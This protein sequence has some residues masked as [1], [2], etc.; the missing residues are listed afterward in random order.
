MTDAVGKSRPPLETCLVSWHIGRSN[1]LAGALIAAVLLLV[2]MQTSRSY[3]GANPHCTVMM[4][5][6]NFGSVTLSASPIDTTGTLSIICPVEG[7]PDQFA[8]VSIEAGS[9]GDATSRKM[10]NGTDAIRYDLYK[11]A[12]HT[13]LWGSWESGYAGSGLQA[14]VPRTTTNFTVYGR[15]FASQSV[16]SGTYTS[17]FSVSPRLTSKDNT[18][19]PSCPPTQNVST[20][21]FTATVT[22]QGSCSVSAATLNFGNAGSLAT[23]ID[24]TTSINVTC[25]TGTPYQIGLNAGNG[26]GAT[27]SNRKMTY[28]GSTVSYQ[29]YSDSARTTNWGNSVGSDTV[30]GTGNGSAQNLV[31]YGRV[32]SQPTPAPAT[33]SDTI[34]VTVTY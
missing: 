27:V 21:S 15:I 34:V 28:G 26:T 19:K 9:S 25:S 5:N 33:Y 16:P 31:V 23:N 4:T 8:C 1:R 32:P 10:L 17:T 12:A 22:V 11:D 3:A 18:G 29:L 30:G 20:T 14:I 13:Q 2:C 24:A 6:V 7:G